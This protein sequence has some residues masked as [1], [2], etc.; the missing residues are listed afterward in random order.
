MKLAMQPEALAQAMVK[1]AVDALT[2]KSNRA[3]Y[4]ERIRLFEEA[5]E[6][7]ALGATQPL[8]YGACL[9]YVLE[10]LTIPLKETDLLAG[11]IQEEVPDE[12]GEAY[13]QSRTDGKSEYGN[14]GRPRWIKDIGHTSWYYQDVIDLGLSG[15][16]DRAVRE[17]EK[18]TAEGAKQTKLDFLQGIIWIYEGLMAYL[19]RYSRA[20]QEAGMEELAQVCANAAT[21]APATF[22]EALQQLH[23]ITQVYCTLI[24]SN[25]T[26]AYGKMDRLLWPL[27]QADL[28]AGR[29]TKD[30]AKL[31]ILDFYCKN[32]LTMGRGEHQLSINE[33]TCTGWARSLNFDAPQYLALGGTYADGRDACTEL[34]ELFID[35]IEPRFKNPVIVFHYAPDTAKKHPE[36]WR[37]CVRKM[38][39]SSSMMVYNEASVKEAL[40]RAGADPE[41]AAEFEHY[42]CNWPVFPGIDVGSMHE[43]CYGEVR[44]KME[45]LRMELG[46]RRR[47]PLSDLSH[48]LLEILHKLDADGVEL[49]SIDQLYDALADY[50]RPHLE[51]QILEL[52]K[53][54]EFRLEVESYILLYDDCFFRDSV[55]TAT[56]MDAGGAKYV[57]CIT[58]FLYLATFIDSLAAVDELVCRKKQMTLHHLLTALD[59]NFEGYP[60]ERALCR[61]VPKLGSDDPLPN[62]HAARFVNMI[63]D[64]TD[65]CRVRY[66]D[67]NA[68]PKLLVFPCIECDTSHIAA[69]KG[70]PAT[71]DGRLAGTPVSQN[72]QPS[73]GSSVNGL[74]ARLHSMASIPFNRIA[75]GAQNLQIQPSAFAGEEGLDRLA[76]ILSG[77]FDLGGLQLQVS[78]V[79]V[80]A[81]KD[82]QRDP[83]AH[84]DL[85]VRVTGYSAVFVDLGKLAQED[86]IAREQMGM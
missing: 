64:M 30:E 67:P 34:T 38:R 37:S 4:L 75:S 25:P 76:A 2:L 40:I 65:E 33:P 50:Y 19:Q 29:M 43:S 46:A 85:M 12:A 6:T 54:R 61:A 3:T 55:K 1:E 70:M 36:L 86:I 77:Y 48:P 14:T 5:N 59:A 79:D 84:R 51:Q 73:V 78:S 11:R 7:V 49:T 10:R 42:G 32:N 24:A 8:K 57:T 56:S 74:T 9:K 45:L 16:R 58:Q 18:R 13:F 71:P 80:E 15:L 23:V 39:A 81:L 69:G 44:H 17:L 63:L 20:A 83:D 35:A 47:Q 27:Y 26:L 52:K 60:V 66:S 21:R 22:R 28:A 68:Y 53:E 41:D 72:A 31:L 62:G 82:A